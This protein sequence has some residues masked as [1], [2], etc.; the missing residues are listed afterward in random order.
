MYNILASN[1]KNFHN[2]LTAISALRFTNSANSARKSTDDFVDIL[3]SYGKL[4]K[5]IIINKVKK[6]QRDCDQLHNAHTEF[7]S[8]SIMKNNNEVCCFCTVQG[9]RCIG[10]RGT[11]VQQRAKLPI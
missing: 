10:Y 4:F 6:I 1:H 11:A 9:Y 2:I 7:F 8:F 3:L 5:Q